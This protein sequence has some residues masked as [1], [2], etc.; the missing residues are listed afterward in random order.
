MDRWNMFNLACLKAIFRFFEPTTGTGLGTVQSLVLGCPGICWHANGPL[1]RAQQFAGFSMRECPPIQIAAFDSVTFHKSCLPLNP[2]TESSPGKSKDNID[3]TLGQSLNFQVIG[4]WG[5]LVDRCGWL[6]S[7]AVDPVLHNQEFC[8]MA[9]PKSM[10]IHPKSGEC[11]VGSD[12]Q[13]W[14]TLPTRNVCMR[15][16]ELLLI[17]VI[18]KPEKRN[19][20]VHARHVS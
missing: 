9:L 1:A 16:R 12:E 20:H 6:F 14:F 17:C 4:H 3:I 19:I 8:D 7:W 5:D 18:I 2:M 11:V 15:A 13:S 10:P